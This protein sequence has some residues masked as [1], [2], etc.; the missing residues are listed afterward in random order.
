MCLPSSVSTVL[1]FHF[2]NQADLVSHYSCT[3]DIGHYCESGSHLQNDYYQRLP[4]D[5]SSL[6]LLQTMT[7]DYRSG[8]LQSLRSPR[9]SI[10]FS[11]RSLNAIQPDSPTNSSLPRNS[12]LLRRNSNRRPSQGSLS[13]KDPLIS[14]SYNPSQ[15][16][17]KSLHE[18]PQAAETSTFSQPSSTSPVRM[19]SY[20]ATD[21]DSA[22]FFDFQA[23]WEEAKRT[24]RQNRASG[25]ILRRRDTSCRRSPRIIAIAKILAVLGVDSTMEST[26]ES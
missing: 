2:L 4:Q 3:P 14:N 16:F 21:V 19:P 1:I 22:G 8:S 18:S 17:E 24:D 10:R 12:D 26:C 13:G 7:R 23:G 11:T 20:D 25:T 6:Q 5:S 15:P 9:A